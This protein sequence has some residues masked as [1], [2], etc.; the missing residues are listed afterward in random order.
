MIESLVKAVAEMLPGPVTDELRANLEAAIRANLAK[1]DL[2]TREEFAVREKVL[3]RLRERVVELEKRVGEL[4]G[5]SD[6]N[7]VILER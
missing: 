2:M 3:R 7:A 4:E 5:G 6:D 1:M